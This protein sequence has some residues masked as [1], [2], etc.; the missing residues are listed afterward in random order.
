MKVEI[1]WNEYEIGDGRSEETIPR[2]VVIEGPDCVI[3]QDIVD[4]FLDPALKAMG[5]SCSI[6][7]YHRYGGSD[8]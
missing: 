5:F 7:L 6:E 4:Y 1:T 8:D 2:G 3:D